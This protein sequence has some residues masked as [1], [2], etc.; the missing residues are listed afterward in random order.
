MSDGPFSNETAASPRKLGDGK[1]SKGADSKRDDPDAE[2]F[3][4]G[5]GLRLLE[6][7]LFASPEP[8][9]VAEIERQFSMLEDVPGLL[10]E[11]HD[12]YAGRG[13][14]LRQVGEGWAFRTASDLGPVLTRYRD[15]KRKLSKAALETL[16]IIAYHQPV[17]RAEIEDVRGVQV[18]KGTIDVLLETGWVRMRGRRRAPG[19]P[20]TYGTSGLFLDQFG[21][22]RIDDLPGLKE[23]KGAGLLDGALPPDF[24]VPTPDDSDALQDLEDPFDPDEEL[25]GAEEDPLRFKTEELLDGDEIE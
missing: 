13:V 15:V 22:G 11:L 24:E 8:M 25:L 7:A 12:I 10:M 4:A 14:V 6:A 5:D 23:L 9:S 17:T 20:I 18:A 3:E 2:G 16:A 21:L 1:F 19:R